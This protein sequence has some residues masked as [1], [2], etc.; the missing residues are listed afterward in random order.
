MK[1]YINKGEAGF[2][3]DLVIKVIND[4]PMYHLE[5]KIS[6]ITPYQAQVY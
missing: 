2:T 4:Y 1:S 6:I 3:S 5:S